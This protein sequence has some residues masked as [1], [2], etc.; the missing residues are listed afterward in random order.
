MV[1]A[2][3]RFNLYAVNVIAENWGSEPEH[4]SVMLHCEV[5]DGSPGAEAF[6]VN[7]GDA[8]SLRSYQFSWRSMRALGRRLDETTR[9][10][11]GGS[12]HSQAGEG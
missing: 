12:R 9:E 4:F 5:S 2:T 10:F 11:R 3:S 8:A 7:V 1:S 6:L